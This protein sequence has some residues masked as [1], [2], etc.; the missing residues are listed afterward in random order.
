V[1]AQLLVTS[2]SD[3]I[4]RFLFGWRVWR[5]SGGN[6][7]LAFIIGATSLAVLGM[8][9]A[10]YI[11]S[12]KLQ[13]FLDLQDFSYLLYLAL[14]G[15]V[16]SDAVIAVSLCFL[17]AKSR[18]GIKS[19]DSLVHT[20]MMYSVNTGLLTSVCAVACFIS[21]A[22]MPNNF[23]FMSF[24]FSLSKLYFNALLATL[25][26]R[27]SLRAQRGAV[28]M[29]LSSRQG[30]TSRTTGE[31]SQPYPQ[32]TVSIQ[33]ITDIKREVDMDHDMIPYEMPMHQSPTYTGS[34][35][36]SHSHPHGYF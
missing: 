36:H 18:N 3:F 16:V 24:Y 33:R 10:F 17:L 8:A 6:K 32:L 31:I 34:Q 14:G 5:L 11:R 21:Y 1:M 22:V 29:P 15:I 20:L 19:T 25:N 9:I 2:V 35:S 4:V 23:V 13:T 26:A 27:N 12:M 30:L 7:P 28:T